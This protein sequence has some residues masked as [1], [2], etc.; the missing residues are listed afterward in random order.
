MSGGRSAA[1][2][3][4]EIR[5]LWAS[6]SLASEDRGRYHQLVVEWAR[7]VDAERFGGEQGLAA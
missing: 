4:A 1:E 2:V 7:A 6:G 3:N 5:A